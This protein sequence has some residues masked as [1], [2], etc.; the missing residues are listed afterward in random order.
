MERAQQRDG[1]RLHQGEVRPDDLGGLPRLQGPRRRRGVEAPRRVPQAAAWST[2]SSRTRSIKHAVKSHA[3][4][5]KLDTSLVGMTGV[6]FSYE[7]PSAAA[8]VVE[9]VPQ[10]PCAREAQG[11]GWS[12]RRHPGARR[13]RSRPIWRRCP[14]RTSCARRCS[15]PSRRR[16]E[17]RAAPQR[18]GAEL[19]VPARGQGEGG[20]RPRVRPGARSSPSGLASRWEL[21]VG[22][23][24]SRPRAGRAG[25]VGK[26]Q[27]LRRLPVKQKG[28]CA[29]LL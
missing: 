15:R 8:K 5:K 14:G 13:R 19:R 18:A 4:A 22:R 9:G 7:D 17:L 26:T 12:R 28:R 20:R 16:S 27:R 6:A 23:R 11:E 3:W 2:R 29:L 21:A 10:G 25:L 24:H 1:R